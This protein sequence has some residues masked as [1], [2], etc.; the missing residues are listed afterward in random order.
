MDKYATLAK[1]SGNLDSSYLFSDLLNEYDTFAER[2]K[3]IAP[4][5]Q[6]DPDEN[7]KSK[8]HIHVE[9]PVRYNQLDLYKNMLETSSLSKD[10]GNVMHLYCFV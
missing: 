1:A 6:Y 2:V 4:M 7:K 5:Y 10:I 9:Y 8:P 3:S